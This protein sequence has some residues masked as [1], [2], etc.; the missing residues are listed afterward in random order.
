MDLLKLPNVKRSPHD[1]HESDFIHKA[2]WVRRFD[3]KYADLSNDDIPLRP[4]DQMIGELVSKLVVDKPEWQFHVHA[5]RDWRD[6][7]DSKCVG[8]AWSSVSIF[9]QYGQNL[10]AVT[11]NHRWG[12]HGRTDILEVHNHR[13][14]A[15]RERA[16][17]FSTADVKAAIREVKKSFYE[18]T[19]DELLKEAYN[20]A[21]T[22]IS[23]AQHGPWAKVRNAKRDFEGRD[24]E[25]VD[26]VIDHHKEH[27]SVWLDSKRG[28][29]S[30]KTLE[31]MNSMAENRTILD[32]VEEVERAFQSNKTALIIKNQGGYILRIDSEVKLCDDSTLPEN[33]RAKLGM[34]KLVE[35][36]Q[37]V[38]N[39]GCRVN[40]E[41]FVVVLDATEEQ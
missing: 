33:I 15:A 19:V 9:S 35:E 29:A 16:N 8:V 17:C 24:Y 37:V 4:A 18:K 30:G 38:S 7:T 31:M 26:Y 5:Y 28:W 41:T 12:Q 6:L 34:L 36:S 14:S 1:S 39:V 27:F 13:V 32:T 40:K 21:R 20:E 22:A 25:L 3:P 23:N 11:C 2:D 10:G